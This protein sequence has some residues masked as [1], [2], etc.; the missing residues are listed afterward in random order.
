MARSRRSVLIRAA[1]D[2][3]RTQEDAS[4][5]RR[6]PFLTFFAHVKEH[7]GIPRQLLKSC[8]PIAI[9]IDAA[10]KHRI[11]I[12]DLLKI[13]GTTAGSAS[14][15]SW[16]QPHHQAPIQALRVVLAAQEPNFTGPLL[17]ND[18]GHVRS[19]HP[20]SKEP[21]LGYVWPKRALSEQMVRSHNMCSTWPPPM[22]YPRP[23]QSPAWG[24]C[25][26]PAEN[27]HVQP[28]MPIFVAVSVVATNFLIATRTER[29]LAFAA[30]NDHPNRAVHPGHLQGFG[31]SITVRGR[32]AFRTSGRQI[33]ILA[34]PSPVVS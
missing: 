21:T 11:A 29:Q 27:Q 7:G 3:W 25:E 20:P 28:G 31:I 30:K 10:F 5:R 4:P 14:N 13:S 19:P 15:W 23:K 1:E 24:R 9:G 8:L 2:I 33:V 16:A 22:A 12:G 17:A 32:K 18:A 6:W 34:I 26:S